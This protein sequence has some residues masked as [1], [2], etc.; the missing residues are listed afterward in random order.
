MM[1]GPC[2]DIF[3]IRES[4]C[5]KDA[6][7]TKYFPK[8]FASHTIYYDKGYPVYRRRDDGRAFI[9]K[10]KPLDNRWV[11]P[12]NSYLLMK[13]RCHINVK[14]CVSLKGLSTCTRDMV[15]IERDAIKV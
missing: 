6:V 15:L 5:M 3:Q 4:V 13:Y 1:H 8:D 2:G 11:V 7:C 10:R 14:I 9:K 12:F